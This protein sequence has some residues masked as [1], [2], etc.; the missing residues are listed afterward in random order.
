MGES[1]WTMKTQQNTKLAQ[2]WA[3]ETPLSIQE[4]LMFFQ[5]PNRHNFIIIWKILGK[6][7]NIK[8]DIL[9]MQVHTKPNTQSIN[10][11]SQTG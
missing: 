9:H 10:Y 8:K 4:I 2:R 7:Y 3:N 1:T 11:G 6:F 5:L